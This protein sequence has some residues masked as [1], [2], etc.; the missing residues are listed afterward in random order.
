MQTPQTETY[1]E[2]RKMTIQQTNDFFNVLISM[3]ARGDPQRSPYLRAVSTHSEYV[4][5]EEMYLL[6]KQK[7]NQ[8]LIR[9]LESGNITVSYR[10][11]SREERVRIELVDPWDVSLM[12]IHDIVSRPNRK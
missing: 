5:G 10:E 2:T 8:E 6:S 11:G 1:E 7:R 4:P 3:N 12:A 9:L